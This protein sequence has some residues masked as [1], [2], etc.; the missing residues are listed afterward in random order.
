[1][2]LNRE[3]FEEIKEKYLVVIKYLK[4]L[5]TACQG[6]EEFNEIKPAIERVEKVYQKFIDEHTRS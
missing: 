4:E 6:T 3:K 2:K 5:A 1:M